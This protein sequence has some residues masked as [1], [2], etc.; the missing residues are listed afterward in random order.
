MIGLPNMYQLD[1]DLSDGSCYPTFKQLGPG[2]SPKTCPTQ[3]NPPRCKNVRFQPLYSV[4]FRV[5]E[6]H[7]P[8]LHVIQAQHVREVS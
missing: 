3:L 1:S 8:P 2:L 7:E 5:I 4:V 6:A